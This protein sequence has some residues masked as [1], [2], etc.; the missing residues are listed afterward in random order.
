MILMILFLHDLA[1]PTNPKESIPFWV[2]IGERLRLL[3]PEMLYRRVEIEKQ[4]YRKEHCID[5][6]SNGEHHQ[7]MEVDSI[8][9]MEGKQQ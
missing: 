6:S 3:S 8:R 7:H 2:E 9:I 5:D 1:Y 4:D